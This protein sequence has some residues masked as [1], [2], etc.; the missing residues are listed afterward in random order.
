MLGPG[1]ADPARREGSPLLH[2]RR[3]TFFA[4]CAPGLEP[5]LH[6]EVRELGLARSERQVGGVRFQGSLADAWRANLALRTAVRVL[7][8][9][10]RLP[11]GDGDELHRGALEFPWEELLAPEGTLAV[12]ASGHSDALRNTMFVA[13]RVK[14]AIVDRLRA[15]R[16]ARP[17]VEREEPD[18]LVHAHLVGERCTLLADTSGASLHKRG[19]RVAQGRAPLAETLAAAVVLFS[20][21]DGRAP[22]VD[23]FCGSGTILIEAAL[24]A[25]RIAPGLF[26]AG[27]AFERL[28]G[29]DAQRF[30]ALRAEL[31]AAA[32]PPRR[33]VLRGIEQDEEVLAMARAN[34]ESAGL[35]DAAVLEQGDGARQAFKPGWNAWIATNPPYG[36]RVG[37]Q[38]ALVPLY[39]ELGARLRRE[40]RGYHL[41]LLSGT[42][43]LADELALEVHARIPIQ[44]GGLECELLLSELGGSGERFSADGAG[45]ARSR[46]ASRRARAERRGRR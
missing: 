8:E 11:A 37:E 1:R 42:P 43:E 3:H 38:R 39:R 20:R 35:A 27:F 28:P 19:W 23:P 21:W 32:S 16:G 12:R 22:L 6:A 10:V 26:R 30:A 31:R 44:N 7:L 25:A 13:Q 41:A 36:E 24:L 9:L 15:R 17:D 45:S 4:T 33:L 29:H 34:L 40:C 46:A 2:E 14:D 18:L 5:L